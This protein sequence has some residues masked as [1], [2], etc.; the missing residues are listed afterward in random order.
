M[1]ITQIL[2]SYA[3][4]GFSYN[5]VS[6]PIYETSIFSF[7]NFE[8]FQNSLLNEFEA[9][10]YSRGKNP[11]AEVVEKK[12]AALEKAEDAKLFA[13]GIAAVS[14]AT[15]AFLKSGDHVVCVKDAYGW[16]S[17]LFSQYLKRFDVQV[18]FV[19]GIDPEDF[20]KN[21]KPNTKLF[22]LESPTTFTF[23]LQDLVQVANF[24]R[25]N[26]IKTVI[27]NTW[28]T[29]VFQ[30]PIELGIDLVVHSASKYIGGHSDVVAGVVIGKKEDIRHI[31]NTEFMNI[32]ATIGP[33]EAW[34]LL[35]GLRT[36]HV[37]MQGHMENT[38][39]VIEYLQTVPEVEE[40]FYPFYSKH[41]QYELAKKQMKGG[42]GLLSIKLNVKSL[43][44]VI[45]FTNTLKIFRRAVSWGG[46]ESLVMPYAATNRDGLTEKNKMIRLH[47]GLENPDLLINDLQ[48][49]FQAMKKVKL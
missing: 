33:F 4:E 35:R 29:P 31:F 24:A 3:E 25:Q 2:H 45:T 30:N 21:T 22:F 27:D 39:K 14:A 32:G 46:Y 17:K 44:N 43:E 42:S 13:S 38:L 28:A 7:K 49:A 12:L 20:I 23:R 10:L 19:E 11:T 8:E 48:N 1:D 26:N 9:H 36:I 18:T 5:P 41:P 16:T 34:L 6:V 15:M 47:I 40:I 37:R